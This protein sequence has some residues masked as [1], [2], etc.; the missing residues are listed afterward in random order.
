MENVIEEPYH[1]EEEICRFMVDNYAPKVM[2]ATYGKALSIQQISKICEIPVAV[3]YRRVRK[4]VSIGLL[5]CVGEEE[6]YRGKKVRFYSCAADILQF[7]FDK[8]IF[9]CH[10][11]PITN[12]IDLQTNGSGPEQS[13]S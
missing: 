10:I 7:T 2:I 6:T 13:Q 11:S 5:V 12:P 8:G 4:M 9:S 1:Y 3:A